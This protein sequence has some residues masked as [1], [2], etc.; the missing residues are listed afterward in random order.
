MWIIMVTSTVALLLACGAFTLYDVITFRRSK[1]AEASLLADIIGSNSTAAISFNDPQVAHEVVSSLRSQPH[2]IGAR[3]YLSDGSSFASYVRPGSVVGEVAKTSESE[4]SSFTRNSLRVS[5]RIM[6]KGDFVGSIFLEL[7]LDELTLRR[8]RYIWIASAVLLASVLAALLLAAKLQRTISEPIFALAQ[9]VR[10]IPHGEEYV[11]RDVEARYQEIGLLIDSFNDMLRDLADR[12]A[13]LRHHRENLESEVATRTAE[14]RMVNAD[15]K[16]AKEAAETASRAKS[17]FLA[18]MSHEIRTPM[19]GILGMTELTLGTDLAPAQRDN[20]LLVRSSAD[21]LLCVINDIL[22]FSKIEAGKFNLDPRP[23]E[24]RSMLTETL[25]SVSLRAHQKGLEIAFEV[26][27]AVPDQIVGDPVRLRQVILNLVGNAIKFTD[28]GEVVLSV[29]LRSIQGDD[30][31]LEFEV[32]DTG[33]GIAP[34]NVARIFEAFEQADNSATRHFGGT[35]LGLTISSHLVTLMKGRISV[36]SELGKGS[37]FHFTASFKR[38][39]AGTMEH[40]VLDVAQLVGKRTLVVDDNSTNRRILRDSLQLWKIEPTLADNGTM[41]LMLLKQAAKENRP[42]DLIIVDSQMPGM[43][44]FTL[45]EQVRAFEPLSAAGCLMMLT[46]ADHPEDRKRCEEFGIASYLIKPVGQADLLRCI[47]EALGQRLQREARLLKPAKT[48]LLRTRPLRVLLAEDNSTNQEVAGGMLKQLGHTVTIAG[49]GHLAV[50]AIGKGTFDLI[51]MDIQMPVMNGYQATQQ[52]R[53]Q[54][55]ELSSRTPII[56]MTAHAMSGDREKC[57]AAGM[58]DYISKPI[59]LEQLALVIARNCLD[60]RGSLMDSAVKVSTG[61]ARAAAPSELQAEHRGTSGPKKLNL[62][63]VLGRFGGNR[64]LLQKAASM[65]PAEAAAALSSIDQAQA[66]AS[67]PELETAAH[68][69]KGLCRMFEASEA[70]Q[71]ALE[72]EV[73]AR[74]GNLSSAPSLDRLKTAIDEAA[75]GIREMSEQAGKPGDLAKAA[76]V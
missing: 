21:A 6:S 2:V 45:L 17:E 62:E 25:K 63:L 33:I 18:N 69:L 41:A 49:N 72:L 8:Q 5:R 32:W 67:Q 65:F 7:D 36:D 40:H 50:E 51:F 19:N 43:D 76:S 11:I 64:A 55:D 56:A 42:Y 13:Q 26:D 30:I 66:S 1:I 54:Q 70:A 47:R 59:S 23:F 14:L 16:W 31:A 20:L 38:A 53:K 57:L 29:K 39:N 24:L 44:G 46:S 52:I 37:R 9:R 3:I 74:N 34:E 10:T 4:Y 68:T 35:G 28:H 48:E 60:A 15:L 71:I 58:D 75:Q 12:D 27:P 73:A 22:D 61:E